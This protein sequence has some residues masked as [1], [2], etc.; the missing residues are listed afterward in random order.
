[1]PSADSG[2]SADAHSTAPPGKRHGPASS[3]LRTVY[4]RRDFVAAERIDTVLLAFPDLQG[5]LKGKGY[6]AKHFLDHIATSGAEEEQS[7]IHDERR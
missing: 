3:S 7:T 1:M 2:N 4:Q 5:W 6:G